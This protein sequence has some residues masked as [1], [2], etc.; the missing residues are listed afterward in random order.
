MT[1][2]NTIIADLTAEV[3]TLRKQRDEW[4]ARAEF[5]YTERSKLERQRDELLAA[6]LDAVSVANTSLEYWDKDNDVKVGKY[7]IALAG[8]LPGYDGRTDAIHK[9]IL[10]NAKRII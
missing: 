1:S 7:L 3:E 5:S 4:R 6:L 2:P 8:R 10:S 9:A